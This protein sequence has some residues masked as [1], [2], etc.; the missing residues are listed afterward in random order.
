MKFD[1]DYSD[2]YKFITS[3][4]TGLI[5]ISVLVPWLFLR[6]PFDLLNKQKDIDSLT[7][8]AKVIVKNRQI[9]VG[10][11]I[12]ILPY[13]S[14][15]T[16]IFGFILLLGGSILWFTKNQNITDKQH[17]AN[18]DKLLRE[19]EPATQQQVESK[20]RNDIGKAE[21]LGI[22]EK[23]QESIVSRAYQIER[24]LI[25]KIEMCY[26]SEYEVFSNHRLKDVF[27]DVLL[28]ADNWAKKDFFVEIKYLRHNLSYNIIQ[29]G[30]K[31]IANIKS[32]YA[33]EAN[34]L[35]VGYLLIVVPQNM[36]NIEKEEEF[37]KQLR[38][39]NS[40]FRKAKTYLRFISEE[41]IKAIDC[42]NIK[43]LFSRS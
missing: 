3:I 29:N 9:L 23:S 35:V 25:Q 33:N 1:I 21:T 37:Q 14:V 31:Q 19:I 39:P 16:L 36:R 32:A 34:S 28:I 41:E 20:I 2:F 13:F 12:S 17:K 24:Q 5:G 10:Q 11:I 43:D 26:S 27:F 4:G 8:I 40:P 38:E 42:Q 22:N 30:F 6:E 7:P 18:L 15:T